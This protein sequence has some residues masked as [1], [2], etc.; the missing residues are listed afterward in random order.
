MSPRVALT[1]CIFSQLPGTEQ[2]LSLISLLSESISF[3]SG[4][5]G[6][7]VL[8]QGRLAAA[9]SY[10]SSAQS[11]SPSGLCPINTPYFFIVVLI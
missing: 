10:H 9:P 4:A 6:L 2:G 7:Q 1:S 8:P 5:L 11:L 3:R